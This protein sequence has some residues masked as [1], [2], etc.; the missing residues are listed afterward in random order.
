MF[1]WDI[2]IGFS[3]TYVHDINVT[4]KI[5][6]FIF[7]QMLQF[8]VGKMFWSRIF[9]HSY[10][11]SYCGFQSK[12]HSHEILTLHNKFRTDSDLKSTAPTS[13]F[14]TADVNVSLE[15]PNRARKLRFSSHS[16]LYVII[17]LKLICVNYLDHDT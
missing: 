15:K 8:S 10:L 16:K 11:Q 9:F 12:F 2:H 6:L 4:K 3:A 13:L 7:L 1:D 17:E 14:L 5:G